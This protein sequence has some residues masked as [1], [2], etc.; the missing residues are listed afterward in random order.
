MT[1]L[2]ENALPIWV[3]GAIAL[4]MAIVVFQQTRSRNSLL[5]ILAVI[6]ATGGL[7][8]ME[9]LW[10]T[11]REAVERTLYELADAVETNDVQTTLTYIATNA[12]PA[13]RN[14]VETLMPL[15]EIERANILGTPEI[16]LEGGS[17]AST[18]TAKVRGIIVARIKRN[19]M[20]GGQ[21]DEL[22]LLL[23]RNADRWQIDSYTSKRNWHRALGR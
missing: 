6:A 5:G 1:W 9:R 2:A 13:I 11:P 17:D 7:L 16:E 20:K 4:T 3:C 19:G 12:D 22:T 10:E 23:V 21:D 14:D 18:A 15:V 8:L